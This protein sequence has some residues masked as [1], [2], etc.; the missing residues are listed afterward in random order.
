MISMMLNLGS[1]SPASR[2]GLTRDQ[3]NTVRFET[4]GKA[5]WLK[6]L[7]DTYYLPWQKP[8]DIVHSIHVL[9][10]SQGPKGEDTVG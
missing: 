10:R 9:K 5:Y 4:K 8:S 2:D 7:G 6:F 1:G 3:E